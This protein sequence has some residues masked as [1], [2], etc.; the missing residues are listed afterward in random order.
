MGLQEQLIE[1]MK[2]ALKSGDSVRLNTI[3]MIRAQIKEVQISKGGQLTSEEEISVLS[4]AAKKRKE[5]IEFYKKCDREDLLT[6]E[7]RELEIISSYLPEQLSEE[8][9]DKIV[10]Q[11]IGEV[12]AATL[13]D[14]GRVM[15]IAMK[16]LKGRAEGKLVQELVRKKLG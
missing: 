13:K 9:I 12:G 5:A 14:L 15:S 10:T 11:I 3:R 8:E 16:Q 4:N 6:K 1:D 2:T 7:K